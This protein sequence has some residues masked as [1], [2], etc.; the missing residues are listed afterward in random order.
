MQNLTC[1][2]T[3]HVMAHPACTEVLINTD[4][5]W[6][7]VRYFFFQTLTEMCYNWDYLDQ[8]VSDV[9]EKNINNILNGCFSL[10]VS[11]SIR[12][13]RCSAASTTLCWTTAAENTSSSP[14]SSWWQ[15]TPPSTSST[16]SWEKL[17]AC[18]W[19]E[20]RTS[21]CQCF[22]GRRFDP[23]SREIQVFINSLQSTLTTFIHTAQ[24]HVN[25]R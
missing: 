8:S 2:F 18:S 22:K 12:M 5:L 17:S 16:A 4:I 25:I 14:T 3:H 23:C 15:E 7:L 6:H 20:R 13:R 10:C 24:N 9:P 19:Y 11:S 1:S 21:S